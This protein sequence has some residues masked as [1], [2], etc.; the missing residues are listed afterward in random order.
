MGPMAHDHHHGHGHHHPKPGSDSGIGWAVAVNLLL[1]V[2]QVVG[3]IFSGSLMLIADA[4]HNLSDAMSLLI[5]FGARKISRRPADERMTFGYARAETVAALINL[6]TLILISLYL[7]YEAVT[8]LFSPQDVEGWTVVWIAAIALV[9]DLATAALVYRQSK[10]SLNLRAAFLHNL[11][12]AGASVAVILGGL[13]VALWDVSLVDPLL[14][15]GLS[16]WIMR[17]ALGEMTE[18]IRIL[19]NAAP[20]E[21]SAERAREVLAGVPGIASVHHLHLWRLDEQRLSLEA[22]VVTA[23]TTPAA[24]ACAKRDARAALARECGIRHATLEIEFPDEECPAPDGGAP[25]VATAS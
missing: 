19:M 5:A 4:L 10:D 13:A 24:V 18:T 6:T 2:A 25:E 23:E 3:G 1:T 21:P 8:R 22:H 14:T 9:V 15:L 16:V 7:G 11:V 17:H 20:D 12:D